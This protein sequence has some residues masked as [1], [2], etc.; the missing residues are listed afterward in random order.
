MTGCTGVGSRHTRLFGGENLFLEFE[1]LPMATLK[2]DPKRETAGPV[3]VFVVL[4]DQIVVSFENS[5]G[6]QLFGKVPRP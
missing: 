1:T 3:T 6:P 5:L 4:A 2:L